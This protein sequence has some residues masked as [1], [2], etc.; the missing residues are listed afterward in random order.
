MST[1]GALVR[2]RAENLET[3]LSTRDQHSPEFT[4]NDRQVLLGN[5]AKWLESAFQ[6]HL[7]ACL[8][9]LG[10]GITIGDRFDGHSTTNLS[11]ESLEFS[12][13]RTLPPL[14]KTPKTRL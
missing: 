4:S 8:V 14:G 10:L 6:E 12:F 2:Q 11:P 3:V 7:S 13:D 5:P 1:V 9:F